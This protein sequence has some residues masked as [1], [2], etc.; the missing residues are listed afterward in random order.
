MGITVALSVAVTAV[1]A[2][3]WAARLAGAGS[4]AAA[5]LNVVLLIV[6]DV[7]WDAIGAAG[8]AVVKTPR[9]DELAREGVR[10]TQARVTT[11]ICMVSRATLLTG[12]YMSRHGVTAFGKAIAPP[13]FASTY[14]ALLRRAGYW[15]GYVGKYGVGA[16]RGSDFDFLRDYEGTHWLT[17][18]S[19]E[20]VHVT[21]QNTRAALDFL[22]GRPKNQP[23]SLTVGFF[24]AHAEDAAKD[25]YLPQEWSAAA[26]QGVTIPPPLHGD[27]KYL[28]ALP[29]F[30]SNEAN[31]G[32]VRYH[33]RFDTPESYQAYMIRYYRLITEVDAAIGRLVDEL[34]TQ[35]V[36]DQTLILV[37]GDNGYF[38]AD[39]GLADKWYPYEESDRVPLV[40]RD[41]R[42]P[43]RQRHTSRAQFALNIDVAPTIVAAA[44]LPVP[45]VMQG[46]DLSPLYLQSRP[47]A[48][49][50]EFFYEHP[51]ITSRDRIP[52]SEAIVRRD[53]KYVEW[54]EFG[55]QQLFDMSAD[56][57]ELRNLA[58]DPAYARQ[59]AD[60]HRRLEAWRQKAR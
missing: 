26:Y 38:Q 15:T 4:G 8:N 45:A 51:T 44:G 34:K 50:D 2:G 12:Q 18:A 49:R 41:P 21:E 35:G 57:G 53:W 46:R 32:R 28:A 27:P 24:A 14:P 59:R 29:P 47:P 39:R 22:R 40:V 20:R 31:E 37:F 36:Y 1:T 11:S 23:F 60:W 33:W 19:G 5:P 7:R 10:F 52:S 9:I 17:T 56:P 43:A 16:P 6:D 55:Y 25:Q 3:V 30:L 42:L 58:V 48:W 13:A 54:P